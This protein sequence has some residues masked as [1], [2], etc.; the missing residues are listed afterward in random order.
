MF[1]TSALLTAALVVLTAAPATAHAG[2][3]WAGWQKDLTGSRHNAAEWR[4]NRHNAG[5]LKLK[6]A[7][8]YEK[9][10]VNFV[11]SQ[12]AVVGDTIYFGSP[13]GKFYAR[14][15]RTGAPKWEFTLPPAAR[16]VYN[17]DGPTVSDGKV[18]FGDSTG[19][20][21]ALD[22]RTGRQ[23]WQVQVDSTV[24]GMNTSSP[25]VYNGRIYLGTSSA[26]NTLPR[27]YACCTF[28]GHIDAYDIDT[29]ALVWRHYTVPEP[30]EV[31]TWPNGAKRF[32]PSGAGVWSSPAIDR[33]TGTLYVG[34]GQNY[35]GKGG[36]FDSLLALDT[37]TGAVR[38][39][40]Q[41]T[42][43]D[44]WRQACNEPDPEGYCPGLKDNTN[45][46]YDI[47]ASPTLFEVNGRQLVGVGQKSGVY[48]VFDARTGQVVWRRQL[49]SPWPS[50]GIGGIQWGASYDGKRLYIATYVA[51]PGK[52][53]AVDP[54]TGTVLWETPAPA[55]G[56]T[57]GG[58]VGLKVCVPAHG[59]P[60]SSTPGVVWL[61]AE[62]GKFRAYD[63]KTGQIL[64][65]YDTIQDVTGVNG[66]TGRGGDMAG[67]G[68]GAVVSNGMVYVQSGYFGQDN[69]PYGRVLLAFGL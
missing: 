13:E 41:V 59:V 64:W 17:S 67:P 10:P 45:L 34:T 32:E 48:H 19:R 56:C 22:Q 3:D 8:A 33:R 62:D 68:T 6:W 18:F 23:R 40:N 1:K 25:I 36:E 26:E 7:Y 54:A 29:G 30:V 38:W 65:T 12:P 55:D 4:L 58:A 20:L 52:L 50:G 35:T 16:P 61:G 63:A 49:G 46:D 21:F 66:V 15:A 69:S 42:D 28:R 60:V 39:T 9:G 37:R 2:G 43:S 44:T 14:N 5:D 27:D 53:F 31:G 24:A 51:Q 47:G 57:T 11:R